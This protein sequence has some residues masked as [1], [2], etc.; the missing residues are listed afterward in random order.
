MA[1]SK[2]VAPKFIDPKIAEL[3]ELEDKIKERGPEGELLGGIIYEA[4]ENGGGYLYVG[5]PY[6]E[7]PKITK[8]ETIASPEDIQAIKD[9]IIPMPEAY[10]MLSAM[11]IAKA[12]NQPLMIEG[13]TS[14]GKTYL[15]QQFAKLM[16]GR[17]AMPY[18][19]YCHG[20]TDASELTAKWTPDNSGNNSAWKLQFGAIPKAMGTVRQA[21]GSVLHPGTRETGNI[22]H[23]QDVGLAEPTV[24]NLLFKLRGNNGKLANTVEL[25]ENGGEVVEAGKDFWTVL[26]TNPPEEYLDRNEVDPALSRGVLYLRQDEL[27]K[28]S[29]GMAAHHYLEVTGKDLPVSQTGSVIALEEHPEIARELGDAISS[30]H[31]FFRNTIEK[32][33]KGRR[34][35]IPATLADIARLAEYLQTSQVVARETGRVDFVETLRKGIQLYYINRLAD[36]DLKTAI[37][38]AF[39]EIAEGNLG[40]AADAEGNMHT[41]SERIDAMVEEISTP[42]EV[43]FERVM[44]KISD[45]LTLLES[46][47]KQKGMEFNPA[48]VERLNRIVGLRDKVADV[49]TSEEAELLLAEVKDELLAIDGTYKLESLVSYK[50]EKEANQFTKLASIPN[51]GVFTLDGRK[52][53]MYS[54]GS[55][56]TREYGIASQN[57]DLMVGT[58]KALYL[59]NSNQK[60]SFI[61]F[62]LIDGKIT[63]FGGPSFRDIYPADIAV[64]RDN[65]Y[66]LT[67]SKQQDNIVIING[68][69]REKFVHLDNDLECCMAAITPSGKTAWVAAFDCLTKINLAHGAIENHT[70]ISDN[71]ME[72][73]LS[74]Q[75]K[76]V[77]VITADNELLSVDMDSMETKDIADLIADESKIAI[78]KDGSMAYV[79]LCRHD[80]VEIY[81]IAAGLVKVGTCGTPEGTI[82]FTLDPNDNLVFMTPKGLHFYRE[83]KVAAISKKTTKTTPLHEILEQTYDSVDDIPF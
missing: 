12:H 8:L 48:A 73:A 77:C 47:F 34:Q 35:R 81:D 68:E 28:E 36:H 32:G 42:E 55:E 65:Q 61:R 62:D 31:D 24:L 51:Y 39:N 44:T 83:P 59:A 70:Y 5:N 50:F 7:T 66:I 10:E 63:F 27:C 23:I 15:V 16:Y 14:I 4:G 19:F 3:F 75:T 74:E 40:R 54:T 71:I 25:W 17:D 56:K 49:T 67:A 13:P 9:E 6:D 78:S 76:S 38:K 79:L 72:M 22:L 1:K 45:S 11:A 60:G 43:K 29:L 52:L 21:D 30:F 37:E 82:N 69:G 80:L 46:E 64:S 41:F 57:C 18:E 2:E 58:K 20:Q 33:E 53:K 26:S